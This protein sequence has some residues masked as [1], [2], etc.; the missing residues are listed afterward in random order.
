MLD[1]MQLEASPMY[2]HP[3]CNGEGTGDVGCT[4]ASS[5]HLWNASARYSLTTEQCVH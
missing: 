5:K 3:F 1:N 2:V 4:Q